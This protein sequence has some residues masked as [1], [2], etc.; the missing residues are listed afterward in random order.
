[1]WPV[2]HQDHLQTG[3]HQDTPHLQI[4]SAKRETVTVHLHR[5][6]GHL[7]RLIAQGMAR[8]TPHKHPTDTTARHADML[9]KILSRVGARSPHVCKP[10]RPHISPL[11]CR[12]GQTPVITC[13]ENLVTLII[14]NKPML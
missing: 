11:E 3:T 9:V 6:A 1:M 13:H 10:R 7:P 2:P 8:E 4:V 14:A 5:M 12:S